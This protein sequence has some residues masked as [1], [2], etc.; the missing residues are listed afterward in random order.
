[1]YYSVHQHD[2]H[3]VTVYH[4][5]RLAE[6]T[7]EAG[8]TGY[9]VATTFPTAPEHFGGKVHSETVAMM[10]R[11]GSLYRPHK[12][13]RE[14]ALELVRALRANAQRQGYTSCV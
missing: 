7:R 9:V 11:V 4:W 1:M 2:A 13:T 5:A 8:T 12:Q 14:D 10:L 6:A 3:Y